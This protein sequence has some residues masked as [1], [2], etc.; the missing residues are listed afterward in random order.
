MALTLVEPSVAAHWN[1]VFESGSD[2]SYPTLEIVR[3][4]RWYWGGKPGRVLE[5]AFGTGANL[6]H[7]LR[8]G[9]DVDAIDVSPAARALVERKLSTLDL[10]GRVRLALLAPDA[11]R[12]PYEDGAFDYVS[13][14]SVLSLLA[15]RERVQRLLAE[16]RRVMKP[17]GKLIADI[18]SPNSDFARG[19]E[20][21]GEGVYL[22]RG[23]SGTDSPVPTYCPATEAEFVGL[24]ADFQVDDVGYAAHKYG[25]SEIHEYLVCASTRMPTGADQAGRR[26]PAAAD[27]RATS[28]GK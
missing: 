6:I 14:L 20:Y 28:E 16:F 25:P 22:F 1:K 8:C 13:C 19:S 12:L 10:P 17:G 9:H 5:Y 21:L 11:E 23:A 4:E 2:K 27:G 24:F 26:G 15:S 7:L 18:N 3:L